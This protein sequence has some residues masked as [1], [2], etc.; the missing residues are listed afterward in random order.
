M[1]VRL[2]K[3][4]DASGQVQEAWKVDVVF[5]HADGSRQRVERASPVNTRRGAEQ[6]ERNL[7]QSL[8][9]GTFG[10]TVS[11]VPTVK[12]FGRR[13]LEHAETNDKQ[14]AAR[15]K[16]H[17]FGSLDPK[18]GRER[19]HL[20][21]EF[22]EQRLDEVTAGKIEAYKTRKLKAGLSKK[23]INNHLAA[24]SSLLG[25]AKTFGALPPT[26]AL[27]DIAW[28][29]TDKGTIDFL[30]FE[31][32]DKMD[33][34]CEH[35][36]WGTMV[37]LCMETGLRIGELCAVQWS[38]IEAGRLSVCRS[39]DR[40]RLDL[41]KGGQKRVVPLTE[42]AKALLERWPRRV[43]SPW[44]F[45]QR[46]GGFIRNPH[47]TPAEEIAA[48]SERILGRRIGWHTLRR[49]FASHLVMRGVSLRAVQA[50]MGHQSIEMTER[51]AHLAPDFAHEAIRALD[52]PRTR[53]TR[54]ME[55]RNE[56]SPLTSG[57]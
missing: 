26:H 13:W 40:G 12:E 34:E 14:S 42:R 35:D 33:A 11:T 45:P 30:T 31:E 43:G 2:R 37:R 6:Y 48:L 25:L 56:K 1:S 41:P 4:T 5:R 50:Y 21:W 38:D 23:T 46:D 22:G 57:A 24:L 52:G 36:R 49:T 8:L 15:A 29:P 17:I 47:Q 18:T 20:L 54:D 3:W 39:V 32:A 28:F 10:R 53:H 7:R 16:R 55:A 27:P 19:G 9:E 44:V 51:Y